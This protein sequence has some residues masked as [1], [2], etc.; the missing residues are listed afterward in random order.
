MNNSWR[1]EA[2]PK[3]TIATCLA[4][5]SPILFRP[6]LYSP[7][8]NERSNGKYV[9]SVLVADV[10]GNDHLLQVEFYHRGPLPHSKNKILTRHDQ[11]V[12]GV[13]VA[14]VDG[15]E[16]AQWEAPPTVLPCIGGGNACF[17]PLDAVWPIQPRGSLITTVVWYRPRFLRLWAFRWNRSKLEQVGYWCGRNFVVKPI[18]GKLLVS[19]EPHD[20]RRLPE[21]YAWDGHGFADAR[22]QMPQYYSHLGKYYVAAISTNIG[23][24]ADLVRDCGL[25]LQAYKIAGPIELARN[26]CDKAKRRIQSGEGVFPS[27]RSSS[28]QRFNDE[29]LTAIA[30]IDE[31][32]KQYH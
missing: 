26:A 31:M 29:K 18:H 7:G 3:F 28:P 1:F 32:L 13:E 20:P 12:R 2:L 21:L 4:V 14:T 25:A 9:D 11:Y 22:H 24:P 27:H 5:L 10:G 23:N 19:V 16:L 17:T 15:T 8:L 6:A 30:Q